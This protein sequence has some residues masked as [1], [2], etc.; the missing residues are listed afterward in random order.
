M[1]VVDRKASQFSCVVETDGLEYKLCA[2]SGGVPLPHGSSW[3]FFSYRERYHPAAYFFIHLQLVG[4]N[5]R[6]GLVASPDER[7]KLPNGV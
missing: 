4:V 7:G 3:C 5:V 6:S 1:E 2:P